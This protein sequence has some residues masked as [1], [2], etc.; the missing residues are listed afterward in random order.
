MLDTYMNFDIY[1]YIKMEFGVHFIGYR[2]IY[3]YVDISR[4]IM[5]AGPGRYGGYDACLL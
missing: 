2:Y 5:G 4:S 3:I 1:V